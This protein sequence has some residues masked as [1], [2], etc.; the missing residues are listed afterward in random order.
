M[1]VEADHA[2]EGAAGVLEGAAGGHGDE[3]GAGPTPVW[4]ESDAPRMSRVNTRVCGKEGAA[5]EHA[6]GELEGA[7]GE[8]EGRGRGWT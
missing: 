3:G 4:P 1:H 6:G 8:L 7:A 5:G 2:L